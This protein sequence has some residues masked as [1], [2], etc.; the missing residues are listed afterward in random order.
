MKILIVGN[1]LAAT[2]TIE[3]IRQNDQQSDITLFCT[4]SVL[5][6]D[7]LTLPFLLA[8]EI[9]ETH[10]H[11][12]PENFF[13]QHRVGV[14][15][16]EK[17]LRI[18]LKR[19]YLTTE[20]K[21]H[22][23]YDRLLIADLGAVM[24]LSV[25]G[26]Q[27]KGVFDCSLLS[28]IK[29]LIKFLPFADTFF[30]MVTNI[31]GFNTACALHKLGKEVVIV[32]SDAFLLA[33]FLDEETGSLLKQIAEAQGIRVMLDNTIEEI[34]GD[35]EVKAVRLQSGKVM[36]AQAVIADF[37]PLDWRLMAEEQA[38]EKIDDEY[39]SMSLPFAPTHFGF[40][41]VEGFCVGFT[42]LPE[43]GR[44]YLKFDGPQNIYKKVFAQGDFLVG[45]VLFNSPSH[46]KTILKTIMERT[47][48]EGQEEALIG[49]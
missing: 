43:R 5:P 32:S 41:V 11:P 29:D 47:L 27:K 36:A 14:I 15:A 24:P 22:I 26:H 7:R 48:V 30:V 8:G 34:L 17:L 42:R 3:S 49:G 23:D 44:E 31:Q 12:L 19:R 35:S 16:N 1:S 13:K 20:N 46:E 40:K 28:S 25:K 37:L 38:Y 4:E 33:N 9:K 18:S 39:Y 2:Q 6:Y 21:T 45:A 10:T